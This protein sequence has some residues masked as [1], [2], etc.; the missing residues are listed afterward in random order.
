MLADANEADI[1][2]DRSRHAQDDDDSDLHSDCDTRARE[3]P[4]SQQHESRM[5]AGLRASGGDEQ[6][7]GLA[8]RETKPRR[9]HVQ[10]PRSLPRDHP[11]AAARS[12]GETRPRREHER[13]RASG[14]GHV[15]HLGALRRDRDPRGRGRESDRR[16]RDH[17]AITVNVSVDV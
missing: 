8:R 11:W 10:P 5:V 7:A 17:R 4:S 12:E 1:V 9:T 16:C 2:N 6:R 14:V 15:Q 3:R 13:G